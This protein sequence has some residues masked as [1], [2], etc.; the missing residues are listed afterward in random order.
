MTQNFGQA[1]GVT[2]QGGG[3]L[4]FPNKKEKAEGF[5][6][7]ALLKCEGLPE[8]S[9]VPVEKKKGPSPL[10][11]PK[12][13]SGRHHKS[14]ETQQSR[15][16]S[17]KVNPKQVLQKKEEGLEKAKSSETPSQEDP[18]MGQEQEDPEAEGIGFSPEQKV[19]LSEPQEKVLKERPVES[20]KG[21]P[22]AD[23][24]QAFEDFKRAFL[25]RDVFVTVER[26][27]IPNEEPKLSFETT[28]SLME[29]EELGV[30]KTEG[31]LESLEGTA[32]RQLNAQKSHEELKE[33]SMREPFINAQ[34][35]ESMNDSIDLQSEARNAFNF[36]EGARD[37][38]SGEHFPDGSLKDE[39]GL[40][41]FGKFMPV[42]GSNAEFSKIG[43]QNT[44]VSSQ[45]IQSTQGV[46]FQMKS[47]SIGGVD[48][49]EIQLKPEHLGKLNVRLEIAHDGRVQ[50]IVQAERRET[51]DL[52]RQDRWLQGDLI[53]TLK[54]SGLECDSESLSFH[55]RD[56]N[57]EAS[58]ERDF[59]KHSSGLSGEGREIDAELHGSTYPSRR[60]DP[61]KIV[62]SYI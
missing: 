29:G 40:P 34:E 61:T 16:S 30:L 42:S 6:F 38:R 44:P 20:V 21:N 43:V 47:K 2:N 60:I 52:L 24:H 45:E 37:S 4:L 39:G 32:F 10:S 11:V 17:S 27:S 46:T 7:Q 50:T 59:E 31:V 22:E 1:I 28:V 23:Y 25:D 41:V 26:S 36:D 53:S 56:P 62:D 57:E 18:S 5:D 3:V 19:N 54:E 51:Y 55:Y 33:A 35:V 13:E 9:F 49:L 8:T 12:K 14:Q 58:Q 48:R 15:E